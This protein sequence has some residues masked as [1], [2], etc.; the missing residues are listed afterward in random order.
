MKGIKLRIFKDRLFRSAVYALSLLSLTPLFLILLYIFK[1]GLRVI[2]WEFLTRLP[3]PVGVENGGIA[4]AIVGTLILVF[5]ASLLSIPPGIWAGIYLAENKNSKL[6]EA[7][8]TAV[9]VLQGTP[10]IVV[11]IIA[12]LWIVKPMG[13]FSALAGGVALAIMMLPVVVRSTEE[14]VKLIPPYLKEAAFALGASYPKT[15][16]RV[17]L[18]AAL[19]GIV[20]GVLLAVSRVAGETAPLLFTAFGNQFMNYNILK[21][22]NALPLVIFNYAMS[23]Y[24]EWKRLA[25]GASVV[26]ILLVLAGNL[27]SR[28]VVKKWKVRF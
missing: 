26:L 7:G 10:S 21:P 12:Y 23:P 2:N 19:P 8:R 17:V 28:T 9:D 11:G 22:V 18:P 5:L 13:R 1:R 3:R 27:I 15:I 4:N 25:W 6:A 14:V 24:E 16:L 20:S